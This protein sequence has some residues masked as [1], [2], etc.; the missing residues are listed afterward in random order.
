V[1]KKPPYL[2]VISA[3]SGAGK[4]TLCRRL[5]DDFPSLLLSISSTTR[6]PRG[7]ERHGHEYFFLTVQEFEDQ[8]QRGC[9]AEWARVHGNYYGTSKAVIENAFL[10]GK[11][12]LLDIDVQGA[13]KLKL[14]FPTQCY[15]IFITP[16]SL[17]ELE[18]RLRARGTETE[19]TIQKRLKNAQVEM[20]TSKDFDYIVVNDS[21]DR[22]YMELKTLLKTQ[23]HLP[24]RKEEN[25]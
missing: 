10:D 9:F 1:N 5:L 8:I 11:S 2:I 20:A 13:E 18:F 23:F 3:P 22:A 16:P 15:R 4:T 14:A 6:P 7:T 25:V 21:L 12:V 24:V 19:E 17:A